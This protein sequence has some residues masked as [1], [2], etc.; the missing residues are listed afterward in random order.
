MQLSE[1]QKK[2]L[3]TK[4][5]FVDLSD[6]S[7]DKVIA[8]SLVLNLSA[9]KQL[10]EQDQ[11]VTDFFVLSKGQLKLTR[12]SL[13]GDEKVIEIINNGNSFA[14]AAVFGKFSGYPVNCFAIRDSVIFRINAAAYVKE[15]QSSIDSCFAVMMT[16]S[17]RTH[18]LLGEVDRLTLHN[19]AHRLGIYLLKD[20]TSQEGSVDI[21][22]T[23]PKHVIASRLSIKPETLSRTFKRLVESG[24]IIIEEKHI[25]IKDVQIFRDFITLG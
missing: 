25:V 4:R 12:L 21:D 2:E 13:E 3:R 19:A 22:L 11:K 15:L 16:L 17:T 10:F 8:Q 7:F 20:V 5:L 6:S 18:S 23:A 14:E 1:Y 24:H 9:N